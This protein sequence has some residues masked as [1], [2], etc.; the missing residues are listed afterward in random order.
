MKLIKKVEDIDKK[1][2]TLHGVDQKFIALQI[3]SHSRKFLLK[4]VPT[5]LKNG[6]KRENV[7]STKIIF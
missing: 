1:Y 6:Q 3:E 4:E 2:A 5:K 7:Q